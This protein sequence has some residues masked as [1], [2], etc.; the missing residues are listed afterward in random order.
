MNTFIRKNVKLYI[1]KILIEEALYEKLVEENTMLKNQISMLINENIELKAQ[2]KNAIEKITLLTK[3]KWCPSS[4]KIDLDNNIIN[5]AECI[6]DSN[7]ENIELERITYLRRK[8]GVKGKK[9]DNIP[10]EVVEYYLT[11]EQ[12]KC[13]NCDNGILE[14]M[15]KE[16]R[17]ELIYIPAVFKVKEHVIWVY[18]CRKCSLYGEN[19]TIIK[20]EPPAAL[21]PKSIASA[22]LLAYILYEKYIMATPLYRLEKH[23]YRF[24]IEL[25]RQV[26]ASWV[27]KV[28]ENHLVKIYNLMKELLLEK[29]VIYSDDTEVQVLKEPGRKAKTKSYM[30]VYLTVIKEKIILFEYTQ[31][32]ARKHP[33]NFL[34]GFSGFMH[35]DGYSSYEKIEGVILV[36]CFAHARRKFL[37]AI[38]VLPKSKRT[39]D[40]ASVIGFTYCNKLFIIENKIIKEIEKEFGENCDRFDEK[41]VKKI[42]ELRKELSQPILD[43]FKNWLDSVKPISAPESVLGKAVTYCLNQ[44]NKLIKF[45][46][47]GR[48][49]LS[50]NRSER[51]IKNFVIGRK[52]WNFSDTPSGAAASAIIYSI[53][54]TA[55]ENNLNV[56]K[57]LYYILEALPDIKEENLAVLLPWS[58]KIPED[59]KMNSS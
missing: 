47:D 8:K 25:S 54:E 23:F 51:A 32:R 20:A 35:V 33:E 45:M 3:E 26:L 10:V 6:N 24:D 40:V 19:A 55:K 42:F 1:M 11:G 5:E 18:S 28:A 50:N 30:W 2:L 21:I 48:L 17:R 41:V 46:V 59:I 34:Q 4:E 43:A 15:K 53:S 16:I 29:N 44:W 39:S 14:V 57:Y 58:N 12:L 31:T 36:G 37:E 7:E 49:E 56:Y 13:P 27:I 9:L 52:N 22:S 38:N